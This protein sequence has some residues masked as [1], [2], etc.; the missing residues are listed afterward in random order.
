VKVLS[1]LA[2]LAGAGKGY[3]QDFFFAERKDAV[4]RAGIPA[5]RGLKLT[6]PARQ[7]I[8]AFGEAEGGQRWDDTRGVG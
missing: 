5:A 2:D 6:R 4:D 7:L 3:I 8:L 1:Q